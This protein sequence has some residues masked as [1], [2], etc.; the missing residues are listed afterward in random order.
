MIR[1]ALL[2]CIPIALLAC[3]DN[4]SVGETT[5]APVRDVTQQQVL[6]ATQSQTPPLILD[7]R[8]PAE[9]ASGHVPGAVNIPHGEVAARSDEIA[10]H[11]EREVIVYC[12]R[13]GRAAKASDALAAAGFTQL[14][15]LAGD[16]SAW[17]DAGLPIE[18]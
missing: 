2:A 13:G 18:P 6:E 9:Y 17:R 5:P 10:A 16:M 7:V 11:R 1:R 4:P 3:G 15:H 14:R 12:E 8:T